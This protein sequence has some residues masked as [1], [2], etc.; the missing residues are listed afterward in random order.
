MKWFLDLFTSSLGR[1]LVMALTGIFLVLFI[2]IHL[3]GNLQLL[4]GD[5]GKAFNLYA[6]FMTTNP[7]IKTV[8]YLN[9]TFILIHVFWALALTIRNRQ[10]RGPEGYAVTSSKSTTWSSRN[11]GILGTII[12]IFI[13]IHLQQ[14][15]AQ[16]HW[17]GIATSDYDGKVVKNLYGVVAFA[18]QNLWNVVLYVVCM[19]VLGFHLWHGF[20]SSFQTLGLNH[21]KYTPVIS[22]V[23]KAFSIVVPAL[24]AVIPVKMYLDFL[25]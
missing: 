4:K 10:A 18:Y 23:G 14:F 11:M 1:K 22:F 12:F 21:P 2:T 20:A 3:I 15:W 25:K 13:I 5:E 8:S 7:L 6:A 9:Y 19:G 24:F 16:M 17:G